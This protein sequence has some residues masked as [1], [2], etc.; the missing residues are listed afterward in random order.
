MQDQD[1]DVAADFCRRAGMVREIAKGIFDK[2]DR[3]F[4]QKFASDSEK[5]AIA[6]NDADISIK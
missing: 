5:L 3:R 1:K 2:T 4:V 6:L